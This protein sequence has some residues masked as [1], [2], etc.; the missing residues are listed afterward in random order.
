MGLTNMNKPMNVLLKKRV[1]PQ[2]TIITEKFE[3]LT[4]EY[5][6]SYM[7]CACCPQSKAIDATMD[8]SARFHIKVLQLILFYN[9]FLSS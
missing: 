7:A 8:K 9:T 3:V 1:T 5:A 2:I 6:P 4:T